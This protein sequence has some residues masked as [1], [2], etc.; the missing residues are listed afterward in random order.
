MLGV[1]RRG[2]IFLLNS[3]NSRCSHKAKGTYRVSAKVWMADQIYI[4]I[5]VFER[6]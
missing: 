1:T 6:E 2:N 5:G 3:G 4:Y